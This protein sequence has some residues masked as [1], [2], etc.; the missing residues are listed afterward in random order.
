MYPDLV[1][2]SLIEDALLA[3]ARAINMTVFRDNNF[4]ERLLAG[5]HDFKVMR[6]V[7]TDQEGNNL[8]TAGLEL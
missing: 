7:F 8:C 5:L 6:T 3:V 2:K 4:K 1:V